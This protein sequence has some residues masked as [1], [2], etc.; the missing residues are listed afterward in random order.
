M[1]FGKIC[2]S[3]GMIFNYVSMQGG[4]KDLEMNKPPG[5]KEKSIERTGGST[6]LCLNFHVLVKAK[7]LCFEGLTKL[8]FATQLPRKSDS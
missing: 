1:N 3:N 6:V 8:Q 5:R 7:M 4:R 2:D